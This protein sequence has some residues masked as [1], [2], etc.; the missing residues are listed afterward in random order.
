MKLLPSGT[1]ADG[2]RC[3][4]C[5]RRPNDPGNPGEAVTELLLLP[6][7]DMVPIERW[8]CDFRVCE[9]TPYDGTPFWSRWR[10]VTWIEGVPWVQRSTEEDRARQFGGFSEVMNP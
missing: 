8:Q 4:F 6:A 2:P 10:R 5:G 3:H 7:T 1:C 9:W